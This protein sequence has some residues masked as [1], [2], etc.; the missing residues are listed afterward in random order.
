MK[1]FKQ[2]LT[3][4]VSVSPP[5]TLPIP[6]GMVRR[7]HV[8]ATPLDINKQ[9]D[10][11][12]SNG[13]TLKSAKGIEGPKAI[14]SW[15]SWDEAV[16]YSGMMKGSA[17]VEF[18]HPPDAYD[19]NPYATYTEVPPENILAIH[20]PWHEIYRY[21]RDDEESYKYTKKMMDDGVVFDEDHK[22]AVKQLTQDYRKP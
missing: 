1:T 10:A 2:F 19:S 15:P 9:I 4:D 6:N 16:E 11:I 5:D 14:Y 7:F 12:K 17:I 13:I 18:F 22:R 21:L 8:T 20:E 3:E